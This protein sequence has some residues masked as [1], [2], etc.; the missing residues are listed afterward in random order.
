[1]VWNGVVSKVWVAMPVRN[2][3]SMPLLSMMRCSCN[4]CSTIR[5]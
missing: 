2:G 1:M 5:S 4:A 3:T